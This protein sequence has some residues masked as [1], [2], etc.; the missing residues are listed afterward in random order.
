[1]K[2]HCCVSTSD[3]NWLQ[4]HS[5]LHYCKQ[6]HVTQH[7][8]HIQSAA[9][10]ANLCCVSCGTKNTH[11]SG[12]TLTTF[13]IERIARSQLALSIPLSIYTLDCYVL[14]LFEGCACAFMGRRR[15]HSQ[16]NKRLYRISFSRFFLFSLR[17]SVGRAQNQI[18]WDN[19]SHLNRYMNLP[20]PCARKRCQPNGDRNKNNI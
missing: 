9:H 5:R 7:T 13:I 11:D 17:H 12:K 16:S 15:C 3:D 20:F 19:Q 6:L 1:M 18:R 8:T 4:Q 10:F 14:F 2:C